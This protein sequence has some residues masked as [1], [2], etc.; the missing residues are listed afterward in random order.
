M[1]SLEPPPVG[2][3]GSSSFYSSVFFLLV[4]FF[5]GLF[6]EL[7]SLVALHLGGS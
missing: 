1:G 3:F 5:F 4:Y 6:P 2:S 7:H